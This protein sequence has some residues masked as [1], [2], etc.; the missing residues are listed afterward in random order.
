M[1]SDGL[2]CGYRLCGLPDRQLILL[3]AKDR[4][5]IIIIIT[6]TPIINKQTT[7]KVL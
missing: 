5:I 4:T 2:G 1:G 6:T 7:T 3:R